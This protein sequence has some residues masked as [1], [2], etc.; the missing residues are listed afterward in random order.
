M[1]RTQV[2]AEGQ[3]GTLGVPWGPS[4]GQLLCN[5]TGLLALVRGCWGKVKEKEEVEVEEEPLEKAL[6]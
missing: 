2:L 6:R 5:L 1:R 3:T 4:Q